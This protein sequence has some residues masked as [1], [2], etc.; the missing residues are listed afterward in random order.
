MMNIEKKII[1]TKEGISAGSR[2]A[3]KTFTKLILFTSLLFVFSKCSDVKSK[4][5]IPSANLVEMK[6]TVTGLLGG[7]GIVMQN[8]GIDDLSIT[9]DGSHSFS[10]KLK[11][12]EAYNIQVVTQPT[13]PTQICTASNNSGNAAKNIAP[14]EVVCSAATYFV[15]ITVSGVLGTGLSVTNNSGDEMF[16][17]TNGLHS[18]FTKVADGSGYNVQVNNMPTSPIQICSASNNSGTIAGGDVTNVAV[19]CS[20]NSY[21]VSVTVSGLSGTGLVI[22]NN[23]GDN[24]SLTSNTSFTFATN[25][26]DN[27]SY[28]VT[29][30]TNPITLYQTCTVSSGSGTISA[31]NVTS[32]TVSCITNQYNVSLT[33]SGLLGS[34][35]TLRNNGNPFD[36]ITPISDGSFA[37]TASISDGGAYN[38]TV[39]NAPG[40]P[41]QI[42]S[43]SNGVG[44]ANGADITNIT[45]GCST[46]AYT[47]GGTLS[48]LI[49]SGLVIQSNSTDDLSLSSNGGFTFLTSIASGA[50]YAVSVKTQPTSPSQT[51]LLGNQNGTMG[52]INVTNVAVVCSTNTYNIIAN[53]T[54]LAGSGLVLQNNAGDNLSI[55]SNTTFAF[56]TKIASLAGYNVTVLTQP[57]TLDQICTVS[58]GIG[59]V[60][61]ADVTINVSCVT[62]TYNVGVTVTGLA[63]TLI[64][65][66]N[67]GDNLTFNSNISQNFTT[68]TTDGNSYNVTVLSQPAGQTCFLFSPKGTIAG[69]S[70]TSTTLNC[71]TSLV[72]WN[73]RQGGNFYDIA[74]NGTQY[75]AIG[76]GGFIATSTNGTSWQPQRSGTT[77]LL[78]G[79]IWDGSQFVVVGYSGTI[80]T[81]SDAITWTAQTS[82]VTEHLVKLTWSGSLY[83]AVGFNGTILTSSNATSWTA[84]TSGTSSLLYT[85]AWNGTTFITA[86][87]GGV[88]IS[89]PNGITWTSRSSGTTSRLYE[90]VWNGSKFFAVGDLGVVIASTDGI[91]WATAETTPTTENLYGIKWD[92]SNLIATGANGVILTSP[93][94]ATWTTQ[95]S[96][97]NADLFAIE[98]NGSSQYVTAGVD[99]NAAVN[100]AIVLTSN[101]AITWTTQKFAGYSDHINSVTFGNSLFVAVGSSG[102]LLTSNNGTT[103]NVQAPGIFTQLNDV[104]YGDKF[105]AIGDDGAVGATGS[106]I[107]S[108]NATAWTTR[109]AGT[110]SK[111]NSITWSGSRYVVVGAS[112]TIITSADGITWSTQ[113]SG[114]SNELN[115][116]TWS[117]SQF[118]AVGISGTILSSPTGI[119][120]TAQASGTIN[121][122]NGVYYTNGNGGTKYVIVGN[123]GTIL[124]SSNGTLWN[125]QAS[126][127]TEDLKSIYWYGEVFVT[128]GTKGTVL[129]SA[130]ATSWTIK[131]SKTSLTFNDITSNG[132][133]FVVTS[134]TSTLS[135][136]PAGLIFSSP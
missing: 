30:L 120:W 96:G 42:C 6:I 119:T 65:Q 24:L 128:V 109:T 56:S 49:G 5:F 57:T 63:G 99:Q 70:V 27:A 51:C 73:W 59:A 94:N 87:S 66:N 110:A 46:N 78:F 25:V 127:T 121:D 135:V 88:L 105:V 125:S 16:I 11:T 44:T 77:S 103:W 134:A 23:N 38:V 43:I 53:I 68:A 33:V 2:S 71:S 48:G 26:A 114:T 107:T 115:N 89:S 18:F 62:N 93:G 108:T 8:N 130:N 21:S 117:G 100:D 136:P 13:G 90:A 37:F 50:G 9:T 126:V 85:A 131:D 72:D 31:A 133:Q 12:G 41:A 10:K 3:R 111:L 106:I 112:G 91:T 15:K 14:V 101:D 86:G 98:Y 74:W 34:G 58:S 35:L 81:S 67:S 20:T 129:I 54:G 116:V 75:V 22:Q 45:V 102:Y 36:E 39:Q 61:T 84:R 32:V 47:V 1:T 113:T 29:V 40:S 122:L 95:T 60:T 79:I 82:G 17:N 4:V 124:T 97:T 83:V 69:S 132:N 80:L 64:L 7:T 28:S 123:S 19:T 52:G 76:T 118:I 104:I 55:T 92:G